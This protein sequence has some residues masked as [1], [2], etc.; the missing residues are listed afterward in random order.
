MRV[1][2]TGGAGYIGSVL[3]ETLLAAGHRVLVLDNLS[4]GQ[5]GPLHLAGNPDYEFVY[6]DARDKDT[7]TTVLAGADVIVPAAGVIGAPACERDPQ[8]AQS[9]NYEAIRLLLQLRGKD[10]LVIYP[11]TNSG[12]GVSNADEP[13][14]EEMAL[15]PTSL[16]GRTK[17]QAEEEVMSHENTMAFRLATAFGVSPRMRL[18]LLVNDF[19]HRAVTDGYIVLFEEGFRRNFA[20]VKDISDAFVHGIA[21]ASEMAGR[22]YNLG[23]DSASLSKLQLAEK[24]KEFVPSLHIL[25]SATGSDPDKRDYVVSSDRLRKA[26]FEAKRTLEDGVTELLRA[27]RMLP[28][29]AQWRN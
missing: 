16:Y 20:H 23:L 11:T 6:G 9:L 8:L 5:P 25:V 22:L 17:V 24:I 29:I 21:H 19:V 27:Y 18:D 12:Y 7:L 13:C 1:L 4:H 3:S 10:Q 15:N 2:I 14:T 28:P 26:G